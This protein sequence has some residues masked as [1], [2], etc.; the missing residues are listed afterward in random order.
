MATGPNVLIVGA[1]QAGAE[2]AAALRGAGHDGP[3]TIIG[4][5]THPP[6][7][8]PPLSKAYL[9]GT[10]EASGLLIRA[11][12]FYPK[13]DIH[14]RTGETV[15]ALD[16]RNHTVRLGDGGELGYDRLVL[17]TGGRARRLAMPGLAAARNVF[18][19]RT[20]ADVD[21][22]RAHFVPGAR[23]VVIGGGY[24][25]LE[26]AAVARRLGLEVT[27][28]ESE[29][30]LL[31][32]VASPPI[33][34]FFA[35]VHREEGVDIRLEAKVTGFDFDQVGAVRAVALADG[36]GLPADVVLIGIGMLPNAGLAE[37]AGLAV[38]NG[39]LVDEFCATSDPDVY[40]IGDCSRHPCN[41]NGGLRRL[42]S[43]PNASE[44][45]RIAASALVGQPEPYLRV[46]WFWSD[47]YDVK[48][49]MT[50]LSTEFDETVVRGST[51]E[52]RRFALFYLR[53][54]ALRAAAAVCD[55]RAFTA[56]KKLVAQ[57]ARVPA[58]VLA[59]E[60]VDLKAVAAATASSPTGR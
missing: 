26:I 15:T 28:L 10:T 6:Y 18:Y 13:F 44:Q 17:A 42:E 25:G 35:R 31:A 24:V 1:G 54:G 55:P 22:L 43:A 12:E 60:S 14:L 29:P 51:T 53:D 41:E 3:I 5:E 45:A 40:A 48:L 11:P 21:G 50:G 16:A 38:D 47:Q 52:G 20:I 46:P 57:R 8:R 7:H 33:S 39:I 30:R 36:A 4:D 32:R 9:L 58:A 2:C 23:L 19:L 34:E 59:D 37:G 56:A 27:V 49:Q